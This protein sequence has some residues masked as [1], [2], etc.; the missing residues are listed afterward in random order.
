MI[1]TVPITSEDVAQDLLWFCQRT[2]LARSPGPGFPGASLT[3]PT[4]VPSAEGAL[5]VV[6]PPPSAPGSGY[7][8]TCS[9]SLACRTCHYGTGSVPHCSGSSA[10]FLLGFQEGAHGPS[11]PP[12]R[13]RW[14]QPW[15]TTVFSQDGPAGGQALLP[16]QAATG[17]SRLGR[18]RPR[19]HAP[20]RSD[21]TWEQVLPWTRIRVARAHVCPRTRAHVVSRQGLLMAV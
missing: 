17:G 12:W 20:R 11:F 18:T 15:G 8:A 5:A 4:P 14:L 16:R 9:R 7:K 2:A 21:R 6:A 13:T 19:P 1:S 10:H 3:G